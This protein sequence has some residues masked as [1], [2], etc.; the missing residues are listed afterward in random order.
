AYSRQLEMPCPAL[1]RLAK[2]WN[3]DGKRTRPDSPR[4]VEVF[5]VADKT[6]TAKVTAVWGIDYLHLVQENGRWMIV[7]VLW[8]SPPKSLQAL[9]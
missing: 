8:Q 6:A 5:E 3:K 4:V 9:K 2:I 1:V 7:N